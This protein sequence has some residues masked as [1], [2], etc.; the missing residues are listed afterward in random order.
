MAA[1]FGGAAHAPVTA[2]LILFEMT[3][4]YQIILPLMLTTVISTLIARLLSKDSIYTLKL[5]RRGVNLEQGQDIDVMQGVKVS[6]IMTTDIDFVPPDLPISDLAE[7]FT[8]THHHGLPVCDDAGNLLGIV[9]IQDLEIAL[10]EPSLEVRKVIDIA[11]TEDVL[12]AYPEESVWEA[13]RRLSVRDVGR[14]PVLENRDSRI[15]I[16]LIRRSDIVRAYNLAIINRSH[17]QYKS[18]ILKLG[19]LDDA[20]FLHLVIPEDGVVVGMRVNQIELPEECLIV[21]VQRGK[22]QYVVHGNTVIQAGDRITVFTQQDLSP[23]VSEILSAE[24]PPEGLKGA[25]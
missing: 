22:K 15:L 3:G 19:K 17:H 18:E 5:S 20:T 9:T 13:L 4:D 2:I 11:S 25:I 1:F 7:V 21:S 10:G 16:G 6:E 8:E 23:E 14:L 12:V 24:K